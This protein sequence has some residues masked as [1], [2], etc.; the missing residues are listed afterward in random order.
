M[1]T[2]ILNTIVNN[3]SEVYDENKPYSFITFVKFYSSSVN[4]K[5]IINDYN[6]YIQQWYIIKNEQVDEQAVKHIIQQQYIALLQEISLTY[7]SVEE[8]RFLSNLILS[9]EIV[10]DENKL[11][12]ILDIILPFFIKKIN[13]ICEYY[14]EKRNEYKIQINNS[15]NINSIS[16][17]KKFI[18][19][20]ILDEITTNTS[21]YS[22]GSDTIS[23][24]KN[25]LA[26]DIDELYD[27][28]DYFNK[29][30]SD[31]ANN[32]E[33]NYNLFA[34]YDEAII[35]AIRQYPFYLISNNIYNFSINPVL[36]TND[37]D[38]LP[39]K[40]FI[41]N[42]KS[43]DV[44]DLVLNLQKSLVEK[45]SGADYYY[46]STDSNNNPVSGKLI[47]ADNSMLNILNVDLLNI[48]YVEHTDY[49]DVRSIGIN[50]KPDKFGLLFFNT[51]NLTYE[52]DST[53]LSAD[54][55]YVFPDPN[56]Y[57]DYTSPLIWYINK[58]EQ[59]LNYTSQ[60]AYG[61][62]IN[63][64]LTQY[65]YSYFSLE[66]NQDMLNRDKI[67]FNGFEQFIGDKII[68]RS[69]FDVYGNEYVLFKDVNYFSNKEYNIEYYPNKI[70]N[71]NLDDTSIFESLPFNIELSSMF[72]YNLPMGGFVD[73]NFNFEN[74]KYVG[75]DI[76]FDGDQILY[77]N[78]LLSH[79]TSENGWSN[80]NNISYDFLLDGGT[81]MFVD[82]NSQGE[83]TMDIPLLAE[84][85]YLLSTINNRVTVISNPNTSAIANLSYE[86]NTYLADGG[87]F[88]TKDDYIPED[89]QT[90]TLNNH[91]TAQENPI[92]LYEKNNKIG[93]FYVKDVKTSNITKS[94]QTL[95][96]IFNKF[97]I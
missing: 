84:N 11:K 55:L 38:Y 73:N 23:S 70:L 15:L 89:I 59:K 74:E 57:S 85:T 56:K 77:D 28:N 80:L 43:T 46:I 97:I 68:T 65:F 92:S 52:I 45:F 81:R 42:T 90:I 30:D 66:Q 13:S 87:M 33:I 24:I 25:M 35:D 49:N 19:T 18:K 69:K 51:N 6:N 36:T 61:S 12:N 60:Y 39:I 76:C 34:D 79:N 67:V 14:N 16:D 72:Y 94:Y 32:N 31:E 17:A 47:E 2:N 8:K 48:N 82:N 53:K 3:D 71:S 83:Y 54:S 7:T 22:F 50:F 88:Y 20:L 4:I 86:V 44:N 93:Y 64:P 62:P 91:I 63:N 21:E 37:I 1:L 58:N 26:V 96:A 75:Y 27:N 95:S 9:D 40:D 41:N 5:Y 10:N 29:Y 78:G